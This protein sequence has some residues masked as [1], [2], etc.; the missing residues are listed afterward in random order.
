M[1]MRITNTAGLDV[2]DR[3][4]SGDAWDGYVTERRELMSYL[5]TEGIKNV[6]VLSG[7]I[8]ASF[9]GLV[10]D[11]FESKTPTPVACELISAGVSSN[12]LFSFFE[13]ATRLP[14]VPTPQQVGLRS[15]I[16]VDASTVSGP[17]FV[18]NFNLLL[19]HGTI[20]AG[21]FAQAIAQGAP[22]PVALGAA[23]APNRDDPTTNPHLKYAD[24]NAQG[25]GY[26]KVTGAQVAATIVTINRPVTA[27][28]DAGPGVKRTASFTIPKDNA[29]GMTGPVFTGTKPFPIT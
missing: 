14:A 1:R 28:S 8:H 6:V 29:A 24:T 22:V 11:D 27:P 7:D 13:A 12:S 4:V 5:K 26:V 25:Y 23:L 16:T 19:T 9:A 21:V 17:R 18:E 20:S 2:D 10:V 15:L 3:C